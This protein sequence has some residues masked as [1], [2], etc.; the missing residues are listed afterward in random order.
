MKTSHGSTAPAISTAICRLSRSSI[1]QKDAT[2]Q[3][4]VFAPVDEAVG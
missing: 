3:E 1:E 4:E 2:Y